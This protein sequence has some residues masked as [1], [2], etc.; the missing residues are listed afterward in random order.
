LE[1]RRQRN[2]LY[3]Q[4]RTVELLILLV[5]VQDTKYLEGSLERYRMFLHLMRQSRGSK[6]FCVPTYDIDL[7]WHAHQLCPLAYAA[8]CQQLMGRLIDHD[9]T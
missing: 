5:S 9:D 8:D 2:T 4:H 6:L 1:N 7:M 3:I